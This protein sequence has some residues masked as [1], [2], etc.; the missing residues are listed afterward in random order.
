V[1]LE[2]PGRLVAIV[3]DAETLAEE[4]VWSVDVAW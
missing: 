2:Q 3:Y 4:G 1:A